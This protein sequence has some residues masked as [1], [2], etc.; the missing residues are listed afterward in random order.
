MLVQRTANSSR[1]SYERLNTAG[2]A[3]RFATATQG[4]QT[5]IRADDTL[6]EVEDEGGGMYLFTLP[7]S[8]LLASNQIEVYSMSAGA[9]DKLIN[10]AVLDAAEAAGT[11]SAANNTTLSSALYFEEVTSEQVR[12]FNVSGG[13]FI[14]FIIP[15]TS[16]PG[17]TENKLTVAS[18]S[19]RTAIVLKGPGDA[20]I[21]TTPDGQLSRVSVTNNHNLI[22][23]PLT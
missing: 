20:I 7:F 23:E 18:Q 9:A 10:K 5:V 15:H 4:F 8:Y 22:A 6:P 2:D 1:P 16:V 14:W 3:H 13:E 11:I 19:D 17:L 12:L 21:M